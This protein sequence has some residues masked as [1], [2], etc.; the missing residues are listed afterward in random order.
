MKKLFC[1]LTIICISL[2]GLSQEVSN[3]RIAG[4]NEIKLNAA[5]LLAEYFEFSY[6]RTLSERSAI[7]I[8]AG[9]PFSRD[10]DIKFSTF[11]Y[12]RMYFGNKPTGGFFLETN[13]L[14]ANKDFDEFNSVTFMDETINE[15]TFGI[16]L[17][18]GGKFLTADG[19]IGEIFVRGGRNFI[20]EDYFS[21][22]YISAGIS[23]GKRF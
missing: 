4:K 8:S 7:G 22:G 20:S 18:I 19:W 15:S 21:D 5:Y 14:Y 3:S 10:I 9:L 17:G 12:Y 23:F 13:M 2:A 11:P 6:E 1:L 16:G